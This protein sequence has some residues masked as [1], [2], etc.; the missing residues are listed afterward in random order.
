MHNVEILWWWKTKSFSCA[1]SISH[2]VGWNHKCRGRSLFSIPVALHSPSK[3][4]L[5][6]WWREH[7][8]CITVSIIHPVFLHLEPSTGS[9]GCFNE[10]LQ[11]L[12]DNL[13][14]MCAYMCAHACLYTSACKLEMLWTHTNADI[15]LSLQSFRDN[16][17]LLAI[18]FSPTFSHCWSRSLSRCVWVCMF[19]CSGQWAW[20]IIALRCHPTQSLHPSVS[21][22]SS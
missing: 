17:D 18:Y 2:R 1:L 19:V 5:M 16:S 4:P 3:S 10:P 13:Y 8:H 22:I 11:F 14:A 21:L 6:G 12:S 15:R 9:L 7:T 20:V